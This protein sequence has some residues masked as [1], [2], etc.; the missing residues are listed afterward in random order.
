MRPVEGAAALISRLSSFRRVQVYEAFV[1]EMIQC[2][3]PR[4]D[5]AMQ[6]NRTANCAAMVTRPSVE[7]HAF[8]RKLY[9]YHY[10]QK[11]RR[12]YVT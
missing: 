2:W 6:F 10:V 11:R 9:A 3:G 5:R 7:L 1:R 4:N 8:C 12:C